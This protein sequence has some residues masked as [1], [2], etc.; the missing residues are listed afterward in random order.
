[1]SRPAK[2]AATYA[3]AIVRSLATD[4]TSRLERSGRQGRRQR[5]RPGEV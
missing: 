1:L 5:A 4:R 3:S 2:V